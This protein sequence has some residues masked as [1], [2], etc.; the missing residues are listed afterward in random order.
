MQKFT[1]K[2]ILWNYKKNTTEIYPIKIAVTVDRKVTYIL[3]SYRVHTKQWEKKKQLVIKHEN[4]NMINVA[5]RRQMSTIE[6]EM[7][8]HSIQGLTLSKRVIKGQ[9]ISSRLFYAFAKEVRFDDTEL[10]RLKNY[11]GDQLLLSDVTVEFLRKFEAFERSRGMMQNT[12]NT[13]FKY[14]LRIITQARKEKLIAEN[15]FDHYAVPKYK[16]TDR[17]YLLDHEL[18]LLW[19]KLDELPDHLYRVACFFLL[20]CYTGLRHGDW[21]KFTSDMVEER[22]I[23]LRAT[24]NNVHV[25]LP[26]GISLDKVLIRLNS[27]PGV[28]CLEKCNEHLK[29]IA[30]ICGIRKRLT[31]HV[32]RHTFGYKCASLGIPESTT[33]ALIGV[34]AATVKVYYHLTGD[35]IKQQAAL[36]KSI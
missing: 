16:Q 19:N 5:L 31:T 26:I 10:N 20:G 29:S 15:P 7:V 35:D 25:V 9:A 12:I 34:S 24:K 17:T 23:K 6:K 30:V 2:A 8:N 32:G 13:T 33:A 21:K 22:L 28:Y 36:L 18:D 3:T 27:I 4:A 14:L 1:I 11:A